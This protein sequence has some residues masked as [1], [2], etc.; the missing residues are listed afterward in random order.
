MLTRVRQF[1]ERLGVGDVDQPTR[2]AAFFAREEADPL[3]RYGDT[4]S[5]LTALCGSTRTSPKRWRLRQSPRA[6]RLFMVPDMLHCFGV[7][8]LTTSTRYRARGLVEQ[9]R[10][11]TRWCGEIPKRQ[12]GPTPTRTMPL[13]LPG[14]A[15]YASTNIARTE[16]PEHTSQLDPHESCTFHGIAH[17]SAPS[18]SG[19]RGPA[20]KRQQSG[21]LANSAK[22][23][24]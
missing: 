20:T 1:D 3:S 5:R 14:T 16:L 23:S 7:R 17:N 9:A 2:L 8:V 19:R 21:S 12:A 6:A 10:R 4:A 18:W 11:R 24:L 15:R 22:A 13:P